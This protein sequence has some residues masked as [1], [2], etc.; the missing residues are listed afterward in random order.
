MSHNM[1]LWLHL[2]GTGFKLHHNME[3]LQAYSVRFQFKHYMF[4][5]MI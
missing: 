4:T 2:K 5:I 3:N 1:A